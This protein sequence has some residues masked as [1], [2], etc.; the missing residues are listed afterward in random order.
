MT[1]FAGRFAPAN[2]VFIPNMMPL[3]K[4]NL[5]YVLFCWLSLLGA[6]ATHADA[7]ACK[8]G[9]R[10][11]STPTERFTTAADGSVLDKQTGLVW[12]RCS[13][14]QTWEAGTCTGNAARYA[15]Q[16][17]DWIK[18][19]FNLEGYAGHH[20]WRI[21]LVPELA[22]IVELACA[23]HRINATV[24]PNT[25]GGV[26]WSRSEKPKAEDYAYTLNFGAG[27][28]AAKLKSTPGALR[29]VRAGPWGAP[30]ALPKQ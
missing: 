6:T 5:L 12:M 16:D 24:F 14:G 13:L 29:L 25:P 28:A 18:E 27:G 11:A 23:G 15:W 26:F 4:T 19:T 8:P 10:P 3:M 2:P 1:G 9:T 7:D 17:T 20:D 30:P 21:P 22:S